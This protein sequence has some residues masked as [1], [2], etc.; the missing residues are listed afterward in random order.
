MNSKKDLEKKIESKMSQLSRAEQE[1]D[2]W[3]NGKYKNSG[4]ASMSKRLVV[5]LQKEIS[6]LRAKLE[7]VQ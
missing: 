3:N 7:S 2:A 5:S 1:S 6:E 4:N